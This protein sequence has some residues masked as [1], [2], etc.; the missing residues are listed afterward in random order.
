MERNHDN[1][2]LFLPSILCFLHDKER[3][4]ERK[5]EREKEKRK[6]ER[7]KEKRERARKKI[8]R[9]RKKKRVALCVPL[10]NSSNTVRPPS[11]FDPKQKCGVLSF[12]PSAMRPS[13]R[14]TKRIA[15]KC[16]QRQ[17]TGKS[18]VGMRSSYR[19]QPIPSYERT[20]EKIS[21]G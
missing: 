13:D 14:A 10:S 2:P 11:I 9:K 18:S 17:P 15:S 5:E 3:E 1:F 16:Q 4:K 20:R 6:R 21:E 19:S 12:F 7:K 8:E